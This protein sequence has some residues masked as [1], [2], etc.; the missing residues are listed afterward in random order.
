MMKKCV[1]PVAVIAAFMFSSCSSIPHSLTPT[2]VSSA[3]DSD[4]VVSEVISSDVSSAVSPDNEDYSI[5]TGSWSI[6][7]ISDIAADGGVALTIAIDS[8]NN[9][10]GTM[11]VCTPNAGRIDTANFSGAIKNGALSVFYEDSF[12]NQGTFHFEFQ[13]GKIIE[14]SEPAGAIT[15]LSF[16]KD[17]ITLL[18]TS[19]TVSNK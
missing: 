6:N 1:F 4:S 2:T 19:D 10:S 18:K 8:S 7:G 16:N 17:P 5:F 11:T 9:A 13:E 15:G 14:Y 12:G 3:V